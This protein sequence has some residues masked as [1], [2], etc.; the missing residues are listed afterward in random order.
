MKIFF[1]F[2]SF[3]SIAAF[4]L[5]QK[6][7]NQWRL[8]GTG[9]N[10]NTNPPSQ[11]QGSAMNTPEGSASVA[12]RNTG[13]LL[14]Y[15]DGVTVWNAQNQVMQNGTML[16]GGSSLL[17]STTAAVIVPQPGSNS[18]YYIITVDEGASGSGSGG[19]RYNLVDMSLAGGLGAIVP[20]QKNILLF[21]ILTF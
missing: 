6:Q 9:I 15:T 13:E 19:I 12:D 7:N 18:L 14:F 10:F 3:I 2:I 20:G 1:L 5:C 21:Q 4:A 16:R 11:V 17:S 8:G